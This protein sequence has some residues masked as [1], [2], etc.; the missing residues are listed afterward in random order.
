MYVLNWDMIYHALSVVW[1]RA[2]FLFFSFYHIP[3]LPLI[4][5]PEGTIFITWLWSYLQ[6]G[7]WSGWMGGDTANV[8]GV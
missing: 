2:F 8:T 5:V 6:E 7:L 3:W 1:V 4:F